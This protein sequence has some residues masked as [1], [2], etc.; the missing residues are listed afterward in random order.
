MQYILTNFPDMVGIVG[1]VLTLIAYYYISIGKWSSEDLKYILCNLIGSSC[2]MFSL[3][4][5]WNLSSV[6]IEIAWISI[7]LIGLIRFIKIG[8]AK[9]KSAQLDD[10][11]IIEY[12]KL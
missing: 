9:K 1:V 6:L 5:N 11:H 10:V 3:L 7:S 8:H 12:P 4:F 2:L